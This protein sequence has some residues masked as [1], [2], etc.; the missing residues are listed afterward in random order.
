LTQSGAADII[1]SIKN[2]KIFAGGDFVDSKYSFLKQD[3]ATRSMIESSLYRCGKSG[4]SPHMDVLPVVTEEDVIRS[5]EH[6]SGHIH[7]MRKSSPQ[8]YNQLTEVLAAN[9]AC[10][11]YLFTN[12]W[13]NHR[14][15]C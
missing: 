5:K 4:L 6:V 9:D 7:L 14:K 3:Q 13:T 11:F 12:F 15:Y 10:L 8:Y 2:P 1:R